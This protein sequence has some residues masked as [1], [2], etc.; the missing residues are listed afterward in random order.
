MDEDGAKL[1]GSLFDLGE[2]KAFF[3]NSID[4]GT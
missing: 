1:G 3:G 2:I 4:V